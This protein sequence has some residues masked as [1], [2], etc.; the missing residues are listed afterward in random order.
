MMS[1][2]QNTNVSEGF[3]LEIQGERYAVYEHLELEHGF[4]S[5]QHI[6]VVIKPSI[7]CNFAQPHPR[8]KWRVWS[9]A[10]LAAVHGVGM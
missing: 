10:C 8:D 1:K 6:N 4:L 9:N 7:G 2:Q 5:H 3:R